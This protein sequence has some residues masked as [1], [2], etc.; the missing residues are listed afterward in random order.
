[1]ISKIKRGDV[2]GHPFLFKLIFLLFLGG[3]QS[4]E[5]R[6]E[7]ADLLAKTHH[8]QHQIYKT[9]SFSLYG[10][11]KIQASH[12]PIAH[13]YIEGDGLAWSSYHTV[14]SDPTPLDPI[15]LSLATLDSFD[16]V[17]Y[18]ARP[19]Q[20]LLEA[21]KAVCSSD[22]WTHARQSRTVIDALS[23]AIDQ[24]KK[25]H[26]FKQI[27]LF[28]YSGGGG[29]AAILAAERQDVACLVTIAGNLDHGAWTR[30]HHISPLTNSLNAIDY[31]AQLNSVNQVHF[32]G[33]TDSV[34]PVA[35]TQAYINELSKSAPVKMVVIPQQNHHSG[36]EKR[37]KGLLENEIA[38]ALKKAS[39]PTL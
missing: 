5:R 31:A 29:I 4:V 19:C 15:A 23:Q 27:I 32:V 20:Y 18:L 2:F 10:Q 7:K 26:G 3:C 8:F 17:I 14:S 22:K 6:I 1:M 38:L 28:G 9:S 30:F 11:E 16:N 25:R 33:E 37:W 12:L 13:I 36:W 39:K 34:I 24:I 21:N 35:L